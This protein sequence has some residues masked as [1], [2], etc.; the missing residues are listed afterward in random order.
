LAD[1]EGND[2]TEGLRLL[3]VLAHPDDESMG[4]GGILARYAAEGVTTAVLCATR[5]ERGWMGDEADNPGL[6]ALGQIRE[7]E[8]RAAATVLGVAELAFLDYLDGELDAAEPAEATGRI[9]AAMRR[10]RPHVVVT[11][12]RT[13]PTDIRPHRHLPAGDGRRGAGGR[14][15]VWSAGTAAAP[16]VEVVL[17]ID[18]E[19][20]TDCQQVYGR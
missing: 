1:W 6:A 17:L 19:E 16:G 11:S 12:G 20:A 9:V 4:T 14:R 15:W 2:M 7:A 3:C 8:L 18:T 10:L 13:G 5:G